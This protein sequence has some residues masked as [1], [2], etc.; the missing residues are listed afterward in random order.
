MG[1]IVEVKEQ[2]RPTLVPIESL[3]QILDS[4][5]TGNPIQAAEMSIAAFYAQAYRLPV[6]DGTSVLTTNDY[7]VLPDVLGKDKLRLEKIAK[8]NSPEQG[9]LVTVC[10]TDSS[11]QGNVYVQIIPSESAIFIAIGERVYTGVHSVHQ[12][13]RDFLK[14]MKR[15]SDGKR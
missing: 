13:I 9:D 5:T 12:T 11:I 6:I 1:A 8:L 7:L 15:L 14:G 4:Y 2:A 10:D 3:T